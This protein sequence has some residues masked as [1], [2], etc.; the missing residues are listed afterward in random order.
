VDEFP[1]TVTG[2]IQKFK[3]RDIAVEQ[4]GLSDTGPTA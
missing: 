2:K 1:M 3:L 4:L